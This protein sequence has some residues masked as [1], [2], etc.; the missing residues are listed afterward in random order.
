ML[1]LDRREEARLAKRACESNHVS[2]LDAIRLITKKAD[3]RGFREL[4][5]AEIEA[6]N[7]T[8]RDTPVKLH[9]PGNLDLIFHLSEY[10]NA[11]SAVETGVSAGWSTLAF[12]L[13]LKNRPGAQLASTDMSYPGSPKE[14]AQYVG[15]VVPQNLR[16]RWHLI[17]EPDRVGLPIAL[18]ELPELDICHYDSDK[19]Y[20]GRMWAYRHLWRALRSGG[21]FLSD[22][23]EDNLGF[24]HFCGEVRVQPIVV[25]VD[26][27]VG[28]KYVGILIKP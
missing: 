9:G 4:F 2:P 18:A 27:S 13:S 6:A 16:D 11:R 8:L 22:D 12:L 25:Q 7:A 5:A 26:A 28:F 15:C 23:I 1:G 20:D 10:V 14:A 17:T 24:F 3:V 21:I 19:S